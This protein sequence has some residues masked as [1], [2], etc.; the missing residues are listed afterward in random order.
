MMKILARVNFNDGVAYVLDHAPQLKYNK[1]GEIIYGTDGVFYDC[2]YYERPSG[3]FRAFAGRKFN[4][5]LDNGEIIKCDG[6]WWNGGQRAV[7]KT[8]GRSLGHITAGSIQELRKCYVFSGYLV[9]VVNF[10][11]MASDFDGPVFPYYDYEKIIKYD[12]QRTV[13]ARVLQQARKWSRKAKNYRQF[14]DKIRRRGLTEEQFHR[15][16]KII[17]G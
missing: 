4:I 6:Q 17:E 12:Y 5:T 15:I 14:F 10:K 7:E 2:Y 13:A 9:D 16:M 11:E 1:I 8:I 3:R